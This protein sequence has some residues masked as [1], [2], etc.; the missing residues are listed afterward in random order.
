[1]NSSLSVEETNKLRAQVGLKLIPINEKSSKQDEK[2][3]KNNNIVKISI[4]ETN[5][6]RK[7]LG[8]KLIPIEENIDIEI[9]N[10][11][12]LKDEQNREEAINELRENLNKRKSDLKNKQRLNKGGLLDRIDNSKVMDFDSWLEKV[13]KEI[14]NDKIR[15]LSFKDKGKKK[16]EDKKTEIINNNVENEGIKIL[17]DK[18]SFVKMVKNE[19]EVILTAKDV[20]VLEENDDEFEN[21]QL[22]REEELK[23]YIEESKNGRKLINSN[24]LDD[25][26]TS[27]NDNNNNNKMFKLDRSEL[28][29]LLNEYDLNPKKRKLEILDS[30]DSDDKNENKNENEINKLDFDDEE[31]QNKKISR[32]IKR[33]VSKFKKSKKRKNEDTSRKRTFDTVLID[34][35][36]DHVNLE[37]EDDLNSLEDNDN[38]LDQILNSSRQF[39]L[40]KKRTNNIIDKEVVQEKNIIEIEKTDN[41]II[42]EN[43]EFLDN[44]QIPEKE[45][46]KL[47]V[48]PVNEDNKEILD[49]EIKESKI[50]SRYKAILESENEQNYNTYGISNVLNAL[51][52]KQKVENKD[53]LNDDIK[54]VYTDD[55]GKVLNTK[56]AFKYL[57]HKFHGSKKKIT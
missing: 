41:K 14:K 15:K 17:H 20:N 10:Y 47:N 56:E 39:N 1:M 46:V 19:K 53:R 12:K 16:N 13:G 42:D 29:Q 45:E 23:K 31:E 37:I 30:K 38:E 26:K 2:S 55:D 51:K 32:F 33:D 5:L 28:D 49:K 25:K 24:D 36:F 35:K 21:R 34:K 22:K 7:K 43:L 8:L 3:I 11:K 54:I 4:E 50:N 52:G 44:L 40:L 27:I 18:E 9:Q 57:S 48:K 6:L